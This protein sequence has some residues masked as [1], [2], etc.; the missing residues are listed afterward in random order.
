MNPATELAAAA[1]EFNI[2]RLLLCCCCCLEERKRESGRMFEPAAMTKTQVT[3]VSFSPL[4][5]LTTPRLGRGWQYSGAK[6]ENYLHNPQERQ[7]FLFSAVREQDFKLKSHKTLSLS[8][9][10]SQPDPI[11]KRKTRFFLQN[12]PQPQTL[13]A[14][15]L[16]FT[17]HT[18]K[19]YIVNV[20]CEN[21]LPGDQVWSVCQ[22]CAKLPFPRI[23]L[24]I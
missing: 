2:K 15:L 21:V 5:P 20:L 6:D 24:S 7:R 17:N 19:R 1:A 11:H 16:I 4:T 23:K 18:K 3:A 12:M 9:S 10:T 14:R 8:L 13:L 22:A